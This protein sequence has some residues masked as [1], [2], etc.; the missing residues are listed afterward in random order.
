MNDLVLRAKHWQVFL[1]LLGPHFLSWYTTDSITDRVLGFL[2][3]FTLL[4][5][6]VLQSSELLALR[7]KQ[8]GYSNTWLLIDGFL[9]LAAWGYSAISEDPNFYIST[10]GWRVNG[11]VGWLF[12]YVIFAYLHVHWFAASLLQAVETGQRPDTRKTVLWFLMYFFWPFGVWFIQPRLNKLLE[13]AEWE[14]KALEELGTEKQA[15]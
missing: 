15:S 3:A 6:L 11:T 9:V 14:K 7:P 2:C 5:W 4:S 8:D 1:L 13:E 10:T 12:L